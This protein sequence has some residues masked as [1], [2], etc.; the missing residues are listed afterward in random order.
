MP[1][2]LLVINLA[3]KVFIFRLGFFRFWFH[4]LFVKNTRFQIYV[5]A[6]R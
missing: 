5:F 6:L 2:L 4:L 1:P 3:A